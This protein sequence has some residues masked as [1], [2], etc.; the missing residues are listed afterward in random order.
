MTLDIQFNGRRNS[1]NA[2]KIILRLFNSGRIQFCY[3]CAYFI[4][5][6]FRVTYTNLRDYTPIY[7]IVCVNYIWDK[8]FHWFNWTRLIYEIIWP[9]PATR[10]LMEVIDVLLTHWGRDKMD[11]ISQTTLSNAFLRMKMLKFWLKFHCSLFLR[12][13]LTRFQDWFRQRLGACQATSHYLNQW[14]LV[15]WRI[16]AS[17]GLNELSMSVGGDIVAKQFVELQE[18]TEKRVLFRRIRK[19][20]PVPLKPFCEQG[21]FTDILNDTIAH[22]TTLQWLFWKLKSNVWSVW[23]QLITF[24]CR[25]CSIV[26]EAQMIHRLSARRGFL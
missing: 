9:C 20:R 13:Q 10:T 8:V 2:M 12:V 1:E 21:Q 19:I 25:N 16:Y 5:N 24:S 15:Y 11:A 3:N 6:S 23:F 22:I 14:W 7:V 17:L 26:L 4:W 18:Y